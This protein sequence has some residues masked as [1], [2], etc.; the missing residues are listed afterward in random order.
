VTIHGTV[1]EINVGGSS[2][3][4]RG[5]KPELPELPNE[6]RVP[7]PIQPDGKEEQQFLSERQNLGVNA[8][9]RGKRK[10]RGPGAMEAP[11]FSR[12]Y[13]SHPSVADLITDPRIDHDLKQAW[14]ESRPNAAAVPR[15]TPGS[16]KQ[17]QG[18]WVVWDK[19]SGHVAT[20][21]AP[22]GSRDGLGTITG[23]RPADTADH[24]VVA[25]FQTQPN[26]AAEGYA[27]GPSPADV[28]WQ[29]AHGKAPGIVET[30]DGRRVIPYP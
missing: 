15:G 8:S 4:G 29:N 27:S 3:Q 23:T 5:S 12:V 19:K 1:V 24:H 21:R 2:G 10:K 30:H 20:V 25:W 14:G 17:K 18:G 16:V 13:K 28:G 22:A 6:A 11:P 9:G 7:I 26:V